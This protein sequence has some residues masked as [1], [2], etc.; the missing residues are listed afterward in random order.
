ME[1]NWLMLPQPGDHFSKV[2]SHV[3]SVYSWHCVMRM[4]L[5]LC[6]LPPPSPQSLTY[7][8]KDIG[9]IQTERHSPPKLASSLKTRTVWETV[10]SLEVPKKIYTRVNVA[11]Q[12]GF[13]NRKR[14]M[15]K[16]SI[17]LKEIWTWVS[18]KYQYWF[19]CCDGNI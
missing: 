12:L 18:N 16:N 14:I 6:G 8:A 4:T 2:V 17:N 15:D 5:H 7:H 1:K 19:I 3:G 13:W 9:S 10:N 11:S